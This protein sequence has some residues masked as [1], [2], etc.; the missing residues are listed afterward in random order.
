MVDSPVAYRRLLGAA[1]VSGIGDGIRFA[2]LPLLAAA[3]LRDGL[4]VAV[5]TAATTVPWLLFGLQAGAY[6][7]RFERRRLMVI[8]DVL[9]AVTLVGAAA[10][11]AAG[12]LTF[13]PLVTVAFLL[14]LGEVL[15]DCASFAFLP[16]VVAAD[17]LESANG[18]LFVIQ[19]VGRDLLG[20]VLGGFLFAI[21]RAVPF[22]LDAISFA[23]S[24]ALLTGLPDSRPQP[25]AGGRNLLAEMREGVAHLVHDPLL[26][27]LTV[28]AGLINAVYLG[29]VAVF[30]ILVRDVLRLPSAAYGALVAAGA[31]GGV[32]GGA[33]A[34][35]AAHRYGRVPTLIGSLALIG[36]AAV[37]VAAT[38]ETAVVAV[39]YAVSGAGVMVW[40]VIA[41]ALR[42]GVVPD[43]LLGRTT[44]AY[45][46]VAWG[47]MPV[48]AL[49]LGSIGEAAG[50]RVAFLAGGVAL[51]ALCPWIAPTL[52]RDPRIRYAAKDDDD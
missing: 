12:W 4:Q 32:L 47:M 36:A 7:D 20:H 28:T 37:G 19:T 33:V 15:F 1:G 43:R 3:V 50:P 38:D 27:L 34:A 51:L 18:R 46:L 10:L 23:V 9:R 52:R 41:V 26:R 17:L 8:A 39:A 42:Q 48:G 40:N 30:V 16:S 29:Q 14:G 25:A 24:A 6:A 5:V 22:V 31:L 21:G 11:L 49:V 44:G 2:A 45:R 35:R 13:W